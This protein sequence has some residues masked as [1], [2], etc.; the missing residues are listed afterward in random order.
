MNTGWRLEARVRML[1]P[2]DDARMDEVMTA[3]EAEDMDVSRDPLGIAVVSYV[4]ADPAAALGQW[5]TAI[6]A[7][8]RNNQ[9]R[10]DVVS[11]RVC[12]EEV[13]E[14]EAREPDTPDLLAAPDVAALL[15]V[16][17]QRVHQLQSDRA[18][19]PAPYARL[20]SG[21][22]WTRPAIESFGRTWARRPGRPGRAAG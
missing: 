2:L 16:S 10:G 11:A 20:G 3:A 8:L 9:V 1:D 14:S 18:D 7:W 19:F 13:H 21:P 12:T 15:G 4:V 22:I 6:E 17:R 5:W